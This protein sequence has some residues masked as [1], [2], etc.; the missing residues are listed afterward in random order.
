M[1]TEIQ[2]ILKHDMMDSMRLMSCTFAF[3]IHCRNKVNSFT[4]YRKGR[5]SGLFLNDSI[6][7]YVPYN[8]PMHRAPEMLRVMFLISSTKS[9]FSLVIQFF[10]LCHWTFFTTT[11]LLDPT[12]E[13]L[14]TI[15]CRDDEN[16]QSE[17]RWKKGMV[18]SAARHYPRIRNQRC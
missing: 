8:S 17:H 11:T 3:S 13:Q 16:K 18:F 10:H 2:K 6:T 15:L 1:S 7:D 9:L 12:R 14:R 5:T 4:I